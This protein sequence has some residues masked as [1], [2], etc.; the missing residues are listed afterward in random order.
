M[1]T[2]NKLF[3]HWMVA[4]ALLL[5]TVS[6]STEQELAPSDNGEKGTEVT[7][8]L[9]LEDVSESRA[10]DH[11]EADDVYA[12][13]KHI[14]NVI[15][16][17]YTPSGKLVKRIDE[18]EVK[19]GKATVKFRLITGYTYDFVFWA[20]KKGNTFYTTNTDE[21][22]KNII[23]NYSGEANEE[24]RDAFTA[25]ESCTVTSGGINK[26]VKLRRPFAQLNIASTDEDHT[27]AEVTDFSCDKLKSTIKIKGLKDTYN[28]LNGE[29]GYSTDAKKTENTQFELAYVPAYHGEVLKEV[30]LPGTTD[31]VNF[32]GY[33]SMNYFLAPINA[34]NVNVEAEFQSDVPGT[35]PVKVAVS[36]VPVARNNRTII[37]GNILTEQAVFNIEIDDRFAGDYVVYEVA[38]ADELA[39]AAKKTTPI[40]LSNDI[41]ST[42][43]ISLVAGSK[44]DGNGHTLSMEKSA[45]QYGIQTS[46][47]TI[48]NLDITGYNE[49]N[50]KDKVIRGIFIKNATEDVYVENVEVTGVA[51]PLNTGGG[52]DGTKKLTVHNCILTGWTSF[53]GFASAS[54][55]GCAFQVGNY[56]TNPSEPS[57]NGCIKPYVT[58]TLTGCTFDEG[59]VLDLSALASDGTVTFK[60]CKVGTKT[61]D[62]SNYHT[63]LGC[64]T[65]DRIKF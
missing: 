8:Q 31:K 55:T 34:E 41:T 36:N 62:S 19:D 7:F 29:I 35:D 56:F 32:S 37:I 33:L 46:G 43:T 63:L 49:R 65:D 25:K 59:F 17:A 51:Y 50:E 30:T 10:A 26:L 12:K 54:F 13:G 53:A 27:I 9:A 3:N 28:A 45:A 38:N 24:E 4:A 22:L 1:K 40:A 2:M 58:T 11:N 15:A 6:C 52:I 39:A 60:N 23:V 61:I 14:N 64:A 16:E 48:K 21:G 44:L 20:E 57:W 18:N 47:G 5:A 42:Q